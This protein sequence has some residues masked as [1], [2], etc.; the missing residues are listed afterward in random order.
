MRC[1]EA[2]Q[3]KGTGDNIAKY[4][5]PSAPRCEEATQ[6]KGTGDTRRP[7]HTPGHHG[8]CE[9]AT[10][11]KGTGDVNYFT[12]TSGIFGV[13]RSHTAERHWRLTRPKIIA[14]RVPSAKKPHSRKA[15]ETRSR[16]NECLRPAPCAKKPHSRKALETSLDVKKL[17]VQLAVRRSHTAE[18]HWRQSGTPTRLVVGL[19]CE[20]A[21]QPKGTGDPPPARYSWC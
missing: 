4:A 6:P 18:R 8:K 19:S 3:P 20:E 16:T 12:N 2:T 5:F 11:P 9:E 13:R 1:E 10:Q 15:L 14:G 17:S 7:D 21:T